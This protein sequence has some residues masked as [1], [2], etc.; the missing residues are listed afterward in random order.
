MQDSMRP[1][2]R[3]VTLCPTEQGIA[4]S[5]ANDG[6]LCGPAFLSRRRQ[7]AASL[8]GK[9]SAKEKV[10]EMIKTVSAHAYFEAQYALRKS[11]P[12]FGADVAE[13]EALSADDRFTAYAS[14]VE[15]YG[16]H[17]RQTY[18]LFKAVP[19]EAGRGL[20]V[21][22]HGGFW[23]AMQREQFR[24]MALPFLKRGLDC[25]ILEYRLMP[26]FRLA[27]LVDDTLAALRHLSENRD[28]LKLAGRTLIAG[29]S[30]G[31]HLAL[32]ATMAARKAGVP[33]GETALLLFSGVY[34]IYSV[35]PTSIGDETR[36][37]PE[38]IAA[39][40]VYNG[41]TLDGQK[42]VFV[43][44]G[45]ETEDFKRQTFLG[46]QQL[47]RRGEDGVVMVDGANHL[48]LLTQFTLNDVLCDAILARLEPAPIE[49]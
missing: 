16:R 44:G 9:E 15:R 26:E 7:L 31:A 1:P 19:R 2:G 46:A 23:R 38:E 28:R 36:I 37:T 27:D 17:P 32:Y 10:G 22:S 45:D 29:H 11:L 49:R 39:W 3:A 35:A 4:S 20:A 25:A 6:W 34:D 43:V 5:N 33:L 18:E 21:F 24:F 30:A 8:A 47:C 48:T 42:A 13:W 12:S 40:S 14:Q 41:A